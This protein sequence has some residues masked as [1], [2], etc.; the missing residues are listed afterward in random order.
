MIDDRFVTFA[1]L[2]SRDE[3][4]LH[5]LTKANISEIEA[6]NG[7]VVTVG[8][9][10]SCDFK[11]P[12]IAPSVNPILHLGFGQYYAYFLAKHLGRDVDT[13]HLAKSVT[14]RQRPTLNV[15]HKSARRC[16]AQTLLVQEQHHYQVSASRQLRFAYLIHRRLHWTNRG[17]SEHV[18]LRL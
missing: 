14:V 13:R 7:A 11:L 3:S 16:L 9:D 10:A 12:N 1:H 4:E 2:P 6:R 17:A 18:E 8:H 5:V 15:L